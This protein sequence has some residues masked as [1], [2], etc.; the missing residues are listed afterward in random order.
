M[1]LFSCEKGPPL[2]T[3]KLLVSGLKEGFEL[4][5]NVGMTDRFIRIVVG[6]AM[7]SLV[8]WMEGRERL[9]G[10][11]GL[12]PLLTGVIGLCPFYALIGFKTCPF[13]DE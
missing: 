9:W 1:G 6:L 8:F 10:L 3:P 13:K 4:K 12:I 2:T 11:L 5:N 7:L